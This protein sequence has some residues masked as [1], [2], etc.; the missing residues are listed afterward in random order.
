MFRLAALYEDRARAE[1]ATDDLSIG[2]K[3]AIA[4]YKRIINEY[5]NYKLLASIFYFLAHAYDDAGRQDEAQQVYRSLVCHNHFKYPTPPNAEEPGLRTRSCPCR[6]IMTRTTG[7]PGGTCTAIS[8][9]S[10]EGGRGHVLRGPV[11]R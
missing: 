10:E 4:L 9:V 8:L 6:R 3:P 11:P 2:L 7:A 5:P 1:D